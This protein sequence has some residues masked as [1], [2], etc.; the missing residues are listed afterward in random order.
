MESTNPAENKGGVQYLPMGQNLTEE[1]MK[2][3]VD[4]NEG[5]FDED[6]FYILP[7][8]SFYDNHRYYFD[9]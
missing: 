8:K 2:Q 5:G 3:I 7:D 1:E 9:A 4:K 6:G